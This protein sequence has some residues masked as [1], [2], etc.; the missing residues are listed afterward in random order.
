VVSFQLTFLRATII[1]LTVSPPPALDFEERYKRKDLDT[2]LDDIDLKLDDG[3]SQSSQSETNSTSSSDSVQT[4]LSDTSSIP[5]LKTLKDVEAAVDRLHRLGMTVRRANTHHRNLTA[6][7]YALRDENG[8][9]I[10]AQFENFA[11]QRVQAKFPAANTILH[12]L[13]ANVILQ[14]R[15]WLTYQKRHQ[16]KLAS[17]V[18]PTSRHSIPQQR[19]RTFQAMQFAQSS[20]GGTSTGRKT[21]L[22]GIALGTALSTTTASALTASRVLSRPPS[23]ASSTAASSSIDISALSYPSVPKVPQYA[24]EFQCPYC[25]LML[26]IKEGKSKRWRYSRTT[27]LIS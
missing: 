11:L 7:K 15:K 25:G 1:V 6:S 3:Q 20:Q 24:K 13:L 9:D 4:S 2:T 8:D 26:G 22:P 19:S 18:Q 10:S 17:F 27:S 5:L 16:Q 23:I 12:H 21:F 14:R